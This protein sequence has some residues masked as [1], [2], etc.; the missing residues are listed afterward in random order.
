MRKAGILLHPTSL[1]GKEGIGTLGFEAYRFIDFLKNL[2]KNYG[3]YF[4]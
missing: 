2:N 4:H 1:S 3:K